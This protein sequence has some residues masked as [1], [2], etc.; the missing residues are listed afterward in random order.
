MIAIVDDDVSVRDATKHLIRSLGYAAATFASAEEYLQSDII[1]GTSCLITDLRMP[2]M[3]GIELQERL[4]ADG[5]RIPIIFITAFCDENIRRRT[6]RAGASG[7][8]N[9]PFEDACLIRC[10][11]KALK[12]DETGFAQQ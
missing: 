1:D 3:S 9:K 2:G 10:L 11:D 7:F 4:I 12:S 8:L 5:R 6:L